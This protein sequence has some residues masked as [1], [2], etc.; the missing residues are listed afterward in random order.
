[1]TV[2]KGKITKISTQQLGNPHHQQVKLHILLQHQMV[3]IIEILAISI[4]TVKTGVLRRYRR[5]ALRIYISLK[6]L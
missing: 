5:E 4:I 1:V 6:L 3:N 2:G